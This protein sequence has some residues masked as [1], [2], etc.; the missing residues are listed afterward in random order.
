MATRVPAVERASAILAELAGRPA[1]AT[2]SVLAAAVGV[3]KATG[4]AIL[5]CLAEQG[6]V[7]RAQ[8]STTYRLGSALVPLGWAAVEQVPG[9]AEARREMFGL[10]G[11]LDAGCFVTAVIDGEMVILDRAGTEDPAFRLPRTEALRVPIRPPTGAIYV[12]WSP[13]EVIETWLARAGDGLS[14]ADRE[15]HLGAVTAIR[16]RG[17]SVGG[18]VEVV[19]QLEGIVERLRRGQGDLATTLEL[20]DLLRAHGGSGR[21]KDRPIDYLLGPVFDPDGRVPLTLT[22]VGRPGQLTEST[23]DRYVQP[24]LVAT[25][26]IT[27]AIGGRRPDP[28]PSTGG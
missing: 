8:G 21:P 11:Q 26:R 16:A 17:Y 18:Q 13:P 14:G 27:A 24:L 22:V 20:A 12:A 19:R 23:L 5:A 6:L 3:H 4:H 28:V 7:R 2:A 10:A 15:A 9:A 1:G 25:D